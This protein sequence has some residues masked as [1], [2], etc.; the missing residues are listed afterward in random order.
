MR[1]GWIYLLLL[2][3]CVPPTCAGG[4]TLTYAEIIH[5]LLDLD[6]LAVLP[7]SGERCLQASSYDRASRYDATS[8]RY[9]QWDA[10]GDSNG[11]IRQESDRQVLAEMDGPGVIW[12]IWSA[13][14]GDGKVSIYLDGE[15]SPQVEMPFK[16][17]FDG[18][19]EPFNWPSLSYVAARGHN[20]YVPI[21]FRRSCKIVAD[22]NWGSYYHVTWTRYPN[23]TEVP[24]FSAA[25]MKA[26]QNE[27]QRVD[28]WLRDRLGTD[29]HPPR[30]DQ[31][32]YTRAIDAAPGASVVLASPDGAGAITA[33]RLK[34]DAS[35][36]SEISLRST[37][38]RIYWDGAREP[39]VWSPV[40][41]FFGSGPGW[42]PYRTLPVGV[43]EGVMYAYWFMPFNNGARIELVN[44]GGTSFRGEVTVQVASLSRS[45]ETYGR[46]HAWWHRGVKP[47][48]HPDRAIDWPILRIKGQG[49]FVG[50]MLEVWNP[51][52]GWWGEGDEKL[53]VDDERFPSIFGTGSEDYF[54]YAWGDPTPFHKPY[55]AQTRN[56]GD[57]VGHI[58]VSRWH[59]TDNVPFMKSFDGF[60]EKYFADN[61]PTRYAALACW[62]QRS[63]ATL[64][65]QPVSLAQRVFYD[66]AGDMRS[67][68]DAP[69]APQTS[70][71]LP[72]E[73]LDTDRAIV[74]EGERLRVL[75]VSDGAVE[76]QQMDEY[77]QASGGAQ[78]WWTGASAGSVA[79]WE[80]PAP[81]AGKHQVILH[82]TRG[83][84]YAIV[85]PSV[86]GTTAGKPV[87]LYLQEGWDLIAV[88]LG[89]HQLKAGA[90][91]LSIRITG[92]NAASTGFLV[93]LD[94]VT[95]VP[96]RK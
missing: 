48:E 50:V 36:R 47:H 67:S 78:A 18:R 71:D 84:D 2:L 35:S 34:P 86:N 53:H 49:R 68:T 16:Q 61:R 79:S 63:S 51:K 5:R 74:L 8:D 91:R 1:S 31:R 21:P 54:G 23:T 12:R 28:D 90:N 17:F 52:G 56:D 27:L 38:L 59:I 14:P 33:I 45:A 73:S 13:N 11:I 62:Y 66:V 83:G 76:V 89:A 88:D 25:L 96:Y 32:T 24:T 7:Q 30:P 46:F 64:S 19:S 92:K 57:N 9:L 58:S 81:T 65:Y 70:T 60:I 37:V 75:D 3:A 26:H 80:I 6:A 40:G 20:C 10:N 77:N 85:Q 93:G 82:L 69:D 39:S 43:H 55:H 41:D 94:A 29:P 87:D 22:N 95:L 72:K 4:Q 42:N 15:T 44:E